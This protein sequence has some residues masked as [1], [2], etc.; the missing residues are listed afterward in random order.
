M[1]KARLQSTFLDQTLPDISTWKLHLFDRV[2]AAEFVM[3]GAVY[4]GHRPFT[5]DALD[6]VSVDQGARLDR[7]W[8]ICGRHWTS[9]APQPYHLR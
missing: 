9:G 3:A 6:E 4:D 2:K 8:R 5:D 1:L 7:I